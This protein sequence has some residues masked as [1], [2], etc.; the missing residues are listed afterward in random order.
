MRR[1]EF[2]INTVRETTDNKDVNGVSDN[3]IV[4]Y[5]NDA[6]KTIYTLIFKNNPDA[7]FFKA[8]IEYPATVEGIYELPEDCFST[9]S[10]SMV[11][12]R[13][14]LTENNNGFSR[15]KPITESERAYM[16]GYYTRDNKVI[17]SGNS[18]YANFQTVRI[19]Y[20][21]KIKSLDIFRGKVSAVVPDTSF[22][23]DNFDATVKKSY[24]H[25]SF[26]D[27]RGNQ[28]SKGFFIPELDV[29]TNINPTTGIEVGSYL[30]GGS[31]ATNVSELPDSCETYL[32]DYVRQRIYTRNNYDDA[33]KQVFFT[34][35]QRTELISIFARNKKDDSVLPITDYGFLLF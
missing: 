13:Y 5:F 23:L 35:Q 22:A 19:T 8:E 20:F 31:D 24:D 26:A 3:E 27:A 14:A 17:I 4:G 34:E 18:N 6:Q 25:F 29:T 9:N 11:E 33:N 16:F 21:R 32:L 28:V 30:L 1:L 12:V 10:I 15:V 7:D 2:L